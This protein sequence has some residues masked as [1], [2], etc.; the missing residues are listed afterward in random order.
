MDTY[1]LEL[2][3]LLEHTTCGLR[4]LVPIQT[5]QPFMQSRIVH[6]Y[7]LDIALEQRVIRDIKSDQR[8]IQPYVSLRNMLAKQVRLMSRL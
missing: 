7:H 2:C 6:P 3:G 5:S 8:R 1:H 4:P